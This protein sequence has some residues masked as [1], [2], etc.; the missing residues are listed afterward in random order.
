MSTYRVYFTCTSVYFTDVRAE[1]EQSAKS[2]AEGKFLSEEDIQ[3]SSTND[4]AL[5]YVTPLHEED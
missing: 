2:I 3:L 4:W 5:M 1:S